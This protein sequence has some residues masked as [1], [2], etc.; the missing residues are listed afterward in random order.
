MRSILKTFPYV[1]TFGLQSGLGTH[2]LASSSP[3]PRLSAERLLAKM[4]PTAE[5]DL[6]EWF[7]GQQPSE[8][9]RYLKSVIRNESAPQAF[10][11]D[12]FDKVTDDQPFNEYFLLRRVGDAVQNLAQPASSSRPRSSKRRR[13]GQQS[14]QS[15]K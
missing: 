8:A 7:P 5:R 13:D 12:G 4:P 2:V 11:G 9:L 3:I 14:Q 1:R 15:N 6:A 10:A